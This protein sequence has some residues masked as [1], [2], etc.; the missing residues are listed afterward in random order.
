MIAR[1]EINEMKDEA[2]S[3]FMNSPVY[4]VD[5]TKEEY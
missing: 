4:A 5:E 2:V 1:L 3:L